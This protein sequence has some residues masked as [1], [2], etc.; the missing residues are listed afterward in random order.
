MVV[1]DSLSIQVLQPRK[2]GPDWRMYGSHA[3]LPVLWR[4]MGVESTSLPELVILHGR[5][6]SIGAT[7][8][9]G[10]AP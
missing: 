3:V 5:I 10:G 6:N 7:P 9:Q 8:L 4:K 1:V 2:E